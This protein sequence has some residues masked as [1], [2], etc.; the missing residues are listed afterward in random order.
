MTFGEGSRQYVPAVAYTLRDPFVRQPLK[1]TACHRRQTL[2]SPFQNQTDVHVPKEDP[3]AS[4]HDPDQS[5]LAAKLS[6]LSRDN[7]SN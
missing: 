2:R 6:I 4:A 3:E 7:L 1:V 5:I